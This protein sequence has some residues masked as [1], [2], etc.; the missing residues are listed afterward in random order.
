MRRI[1]CN[2]VGHGIMMVSCVY[3]A[4]EGTALAARTLYLYFLY[5]KQYETGIESVVLGMVTAAALAR[6]NR[7]TCKSALQS[8]FEHG[9]LFGQST[10]SSKCASSPA[11]KAATAAL[12]VLPDFAGTAQSESV[13]CGGLGY[14][15][16]DWGVLLM[17]E[18]AIHE[19]PTSYCV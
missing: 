8:A 9:L 13:H 18:W 6:G 16:G 17:Y 11:K 14:F 2:A 12:M 4:S 1:V 15:V 3:K 19:I 7:G 5:L 10:T